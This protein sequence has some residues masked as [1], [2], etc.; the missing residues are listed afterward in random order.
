M[1]LV[2]IAFT[3]TCHVDNAAH[4]CAVIQIDV[5]VTMA[6]CACAPELKLSIDAF[7]PRYTPSEFLFCDVGLA[8]RY[9][10]PGNRDLSVG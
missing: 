5:T 2:H 3:M 8:A 10:P 1:N 4:V 9:L 7:L 6:Y